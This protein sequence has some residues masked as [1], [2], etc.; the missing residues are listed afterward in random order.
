VRA[1]WFGLYDSLDANQREQ[2]RVAIRDGMDHMGQTRN[3]PRRPPRG[4]AGLGLR[5]HFEE[6]RVDASM[7]ARI[8]LV[9]GEPNT[10]TA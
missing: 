8:H 10:I 3:A 4:H 2:V 5:A 9:C 7:P 6:L 1:A